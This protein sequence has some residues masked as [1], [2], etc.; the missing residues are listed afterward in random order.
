MLTINVSLFGLLDIWS[1]AALGM[2]C[3]N[4]I[5]ADKVPGVALVA[6]A[7]ELSPAVLLKPP[8]RTAVTPL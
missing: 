5:K 8:T 4:G 1:M 7:I 3:P 6:I 2:P